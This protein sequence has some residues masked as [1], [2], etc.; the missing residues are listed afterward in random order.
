[1]PLI[2]NSLKMG[3]HTQNTHTH[4]HTP[5]NTHILI[6]Q[7]KVILIKKPGACQ[8]KAGMCLD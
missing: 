7:T 1:M 3:T 4:T 2:I 6:L 8:L 5:A